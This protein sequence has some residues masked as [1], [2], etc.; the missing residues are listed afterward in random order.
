MYEIKVYNQKELDSLDKKF[1]EYTKIYLID[2][3]FILNE[4]WGNSSVVARENSSVEAWGNSIIKTFETKIIKSLKEESI[5]INIDNE[6]TVEYID[7]TATVLNKKKQY[8]NINN[9]CDI[10]KK[11]L[12]NDKK[13]KLY[14]SVNPNN[15]KDFYTN[16]IK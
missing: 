2:S 4:A 7:D 14:K 3:K 8:Y 9:F 6:S 16:T 13:I 1:T 5:L 15:R 12:I 11:N 10:Y